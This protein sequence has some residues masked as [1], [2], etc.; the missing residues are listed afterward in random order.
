MVGREE[1]RGRKVKEES[2]SLGIGKI[3]RKEKRKVL[4]EE[5]KKEGGEAN[6][7]R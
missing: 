5:D 1:G 3:Y 2:W 6:E 7:E 4:L